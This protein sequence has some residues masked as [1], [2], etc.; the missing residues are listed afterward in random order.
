[1]TRFSVPLRPK[2]LIG[3]SVAQD[4]QEIFLNG[5]R[6]TQDEIVFFE[7]LAGMH[8]PDGSYWVDYN[9]GEWGSVDNSLSNEST[10]PTMKDNR[11]FE[12][13]MFEDYGVTMPST[14][15]YP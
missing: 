5:E 9:T 13:R 10:A 11:Y 8:L 1:M 14:V 12:D 4:N 3:N 7:Q 6:L 2:P 15:V